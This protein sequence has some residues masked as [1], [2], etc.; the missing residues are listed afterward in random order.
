[1]V[2]SLNVDDGVSVT[3]ETEE[4]HV[5]SEKQIGSKEV[6]S[7]DKVESTF[8]DKKPHRPILQ[9]FPPRPF[10]KQNRAFQKS[11]YDDYEW[12]EY[13]EVNV[14][15]YCFPCRVFLNKVVAFNKDGYFN[16]KNAKGVSGGLASHEN[17]DHGTAMK[18]WD[19][20]KNRDLSSSSIVHFIQ[21]K[22]EHKSV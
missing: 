7:N 6:K 13:D 15:C 5:S 9:K 17:Q 19:D 3:C 14:K 2:D 22:S 11:W 10:G 4:S 8:N 18:L 16:W 20:R 21:N 1:M 12:L